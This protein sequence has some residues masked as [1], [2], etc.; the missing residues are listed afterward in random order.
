MG[1]DAPDQVEK[2]H[3]ADNGILQQIGGGDIPVCGGINLDPHKHG[4]QR[5]QIPGREK[6]VL[7]GAPEFH[8]EGPEKTQASGGSHYLVHTISFPVRASR[9]W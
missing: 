8:P 4:G 3:G 7:Q 1:Q 5:R 6:D 9:R 2:A